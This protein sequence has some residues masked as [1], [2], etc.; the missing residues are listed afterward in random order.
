MSSAMPLVVKIIAALVVL[1]VGAIVFMRLKHDRQRS[2]LEAAIR[3]YVEARG[4]QISF[5]G[6]GFQV[7]GPLGAGYERLS[8]YQVMCK[9]GQEA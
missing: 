4:G 9:P 8:I 2:K 7:Q 6:D 1:V 3:S 5:S